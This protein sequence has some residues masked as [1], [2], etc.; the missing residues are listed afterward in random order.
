M[1]TTITLPISHQAKILLEVGDHIT[2]KTILAKLGESSEGET[3]HL[4]KLLGVANDKISHYLKKNIGE[5]IEEGEVIAQK[6]G[7]FSHSVVRSPIKAKLAQLDLSKG[8]INLLKYSK[9][10]K[11]DLVSPIEGK[12]VTIGKSAIEIEIN[13][14]LFKGV[15]GEGQDAVGDL[16]YL[17]GENL[18][19][20]DSQN[21]VEEAIV[22]VK[23]MQ[24]ATI[25]KFSVIG[26]KGAVIVKVNGEPS[27][28]WIQVE[29][30]VFSKLTDFADKKVWLRPTEKQLVILD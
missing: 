23:S 5:D 24:E 22:L 7:L 30:N 27:L 13:N 18:G 8:S 9:E 16:C 11:A 2:S 10:K 26:A 19:I 29:E 21:D 25:V 28:P 3:I 17:K 14:H 4:A 1:S 15:K 6:K 12:V 20:S